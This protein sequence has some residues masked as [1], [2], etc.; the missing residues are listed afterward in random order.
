MRLEFATVTL[1][2]LGGPHFYGES[3]AARSGRP[4]GSRSTTRNWTAAWRAFFVVLIVDEPAPRLVRY[5]I[6]CWRAGPHLRSAHT[7]LVDGA[8]PGF[9]FLA[10]QAFRLCG[11]QAVEEGPPSSA[12]S[13]GPLML[14]ADRCSTVE[15]N[16]GAAG[17]CVYAGST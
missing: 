2:R 8:M 11:V 7:R 10:C 12:E 15:A 4:A 13:S 9:L 14:P 3:L 6:S 1:L 16:S 17:L 5:P